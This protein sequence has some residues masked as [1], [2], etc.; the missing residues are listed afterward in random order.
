MQAVTAIVCQPIS[1]RNEKEPKIILY[2]TVICL[3]LLPVEQ[4]PWEWST[5][6]TEEG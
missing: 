5:A 2:G 4:G 1:S 6:R 3:K